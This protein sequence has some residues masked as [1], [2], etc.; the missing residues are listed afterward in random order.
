MTYRLSID[1]NVFGVILKVTAVDGYEVWP[2]SNKRWRVISEEHVQIGCDI[3]LW[4]VLD[5]GKGVWSWLAGE[6]RLSYG[7]ANGAQKSTYS[8]GSRRAPRRL[9]TGIK[10]SGT[11]V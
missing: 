2:L 9:E 7:L 1:V 4:G 5:N 10:L 3:C 8:K 6:K 11:Q